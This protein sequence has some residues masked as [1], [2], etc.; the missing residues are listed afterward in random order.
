M[1]EL[2]DFENGVATRDCEDE[3]GERFVRSQVRF[4]DGKWPMDDASPAYLKR[5]RTAAEAMENDM[6]TLV[7][8]RWWA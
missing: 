7:R 2:M 6:R 4:L 1:S 8:T 3:I 5:L